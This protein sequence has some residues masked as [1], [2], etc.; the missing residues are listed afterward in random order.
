MSRSAGDVRIANAWVA[1]TAA[2][3]AIPSQTLVRGGRAG[4]ESRGGSIAGANWLSGLNDVF[5]G[6][7]RG[8]EE[9]E[10]ERGEQS[11]PGAGVVHQV[12]AQ[13]RLRRRRGR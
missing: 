1:I 13:Q 3:L 12:P 8:D 5:E 2:K 9:N 7:E 11:N 6:N 4:R 10:V